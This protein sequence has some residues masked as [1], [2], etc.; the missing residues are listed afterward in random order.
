M[1]IDLGFLNL[2][3]RDTGSVYFKYAPV[4]CVDFHTH[5]ESFVNVVAMTDRYGM[6][7]SENG[8]VQEGSR[9]LDGYSR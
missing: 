9:Y 5:G 4:Y 7:D 2:S 8:A 3:S 6:Y 1:G